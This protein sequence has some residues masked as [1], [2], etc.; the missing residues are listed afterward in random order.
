M[1]APQQPLGYGIGLRTNHF[2]R[3]LEE[4][5]KVDWVEAISENFMRPGGR[6]LHVLE[7][8]RSEVPVVLHGVSLSIGGTDPLNRTYL[9]ALRSL[10]DRISPAMVSDHLCWC[11]HGGRYVHDLWPVPFTEEALAH[12]ASRVGEVQ[13]SLGR[14][15]LL[16]NVSSYVTFRASEMTEWEFLS[17]LTR[18]AGCALLLDVNNV[19]VSAHNHGFDP[20]EYLRGIPVGR[21]GQFHLAGHTDRGSF[22][23]DSHDGPVPDAVWALYR[24]A[25]RRFGEGPTLIEW[26][27]QIPELPILVAES[28]KAKAHARRALRDREAA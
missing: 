2:S 7:K 27:E 12:I 23:L 10:I 17:E 21:V 25:V 5:P 16:E 1:S 15:I 28:E 3:F 11:S 13:E 8:V 26:D 18:R 19:F 9:Q 24:E 22:L 4:S 6:P 14:Q 20:L